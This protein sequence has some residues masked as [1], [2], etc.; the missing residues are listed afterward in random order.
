MQGVIFTLLYLLRLTLYPKKCSI[1]EK[2]HGLLRRMYIVLLLD[3]IFW[4]H[5]LGTFALWYH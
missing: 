3:E 1:S 5:Q 4:K 2:V